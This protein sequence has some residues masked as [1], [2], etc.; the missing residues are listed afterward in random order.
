[1]VASLECGINSGKLSGEHGMKIDVKKKKK[2]DC[3]NKKDAWYDWF[4]LND[5]KT[6]GGYSVCPE[7]SEYIVGW[8]K[9][10]SW[11]PPSEKVADFGCGVG[12]F[13][14]LLINKGKSFSYGV[15]YSKV[16]IQFAKE[17]NPGNENLFF[18]GDLESSQPFNIFDYDVAV[19]LETLEH[20]KDD[21]SC[22]SFIKRGKRCIMSLPSFDY[23]S[24]FRHF[25]SLEDC[26]KRYDSLIDIIDTY[27]LNMENN[28]K[29]WY[30]NSIRK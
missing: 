29:I 27:S 15:D 20:I 11:L 5:K 3:R 12:Q 2:D 28:N 18:V 26:I 6:N 30:I 14:K 19:F 8:E 21:L 16:A 17:N 13:A 4:Y 25:V 23:V 7:K 9:I 24:H 10:L 1:M 22:L